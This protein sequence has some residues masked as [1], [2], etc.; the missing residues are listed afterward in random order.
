[1]I[2]YVFAYF[3]SFLF[4]YIYMIHIKLSLIIVQPKW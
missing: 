4:S 3:I 2:E 1:M